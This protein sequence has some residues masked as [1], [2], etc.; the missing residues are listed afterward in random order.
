MINVP[1]TLEMKVPRNLRNTTYRLTVEG[2]TPSW[3]RK[4]VNTSELIFEQKAVAILVQLDRL[5]FRHETT[6]Q[7]RCIPIYPDLSGYVHTVDAYIMGPSGHILRKWENQQ[8]TA[9]TLV[10]EVSSFTC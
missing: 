10:L 9:G 5:I 4:F 6:V 7:F 1:Q 3:D 8:T 2:L